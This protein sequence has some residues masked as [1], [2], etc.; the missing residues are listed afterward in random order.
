MIA[1]ADI[2]HLHTLWSPLVAAAARFSERLGVPYVLSPHGMLD[3]WSLRQ[4]AL[5]KHVWL[6]LVERDT[7]FAAAR[8]VFTTAAERDLA[9]ATYAAPP[10]AEVIAL[11]ADP[12]P[13][14]ARALRSAFFSANPSL[15][16]RPILIFMGRLHEKKRPDV[17][18]KAMLD[19]RKAIPN[20]M[21][22]VVGAGRKGTLATLRKLVEDRG[23][24]DNVLFT[25][26]LEGAQKWEALVSSK[27]FLLPSQQENFAIAAAEALRS[28]IPVILT[29]KVNIWPEVVGAGAGIAL[30]EE[31]LVEIMASEAIGIL[32]DENLHKEMSFNAAAL[33]AQLYTWEVCSRKTHAMYE[34]VIGGI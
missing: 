24:E 28:A 10:K 16:T 32:T 21:L 12:L 2:V 13:T 17:A 26:M 19:I 27:I 6:T 34:D 22:L 4:G 29:K 1:E 18:I 9:L 7:L 31:N 14:N 5:K 11:G 23:L 30:E 3:P 8:L 15:R 33:A 25:G 20:A